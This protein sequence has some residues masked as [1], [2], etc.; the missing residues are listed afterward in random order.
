MMLRNL[1]FSE[2]SW[3]IVCMSLCGEKQ[4]YRDR[5][6]SS[7]KDQMCLHQVKSIKMDR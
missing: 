1:G 6:R 5:Q 2:L 3:S 7:H 4:I